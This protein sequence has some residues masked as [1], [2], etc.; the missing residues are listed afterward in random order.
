M[1]RSDKLIRVS[2]TSFMRRAT[3]SLI[4]LPVID[5]CCLYFFSAS[6]ASFTRAAITSGTSLPVAANWVRYFPKATLISCIL[7]ANASGSSLEESDR[8]L[9]T[10]LNSLIRADIVPFNSLPA[11]DVWKRGDRISRK[12]L[13]YSLSTGLSLA[14]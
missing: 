6:L 4:S 14:W 11:V 2:L 9:R 5:I 1:D 10:S 3:V 12:T 7:E 13:S 8:V